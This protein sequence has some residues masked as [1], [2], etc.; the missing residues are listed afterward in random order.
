MRGS[1]ILGLAAGI[2]LLGQALPVEAGLL[3]STVDVSVLFPDQAT[4]FLDAGNK[5]VGDQIE[6]PVG[7]FSS[8]N[9]NL[10]VDITDTQIIVSLNGTDTLFSSATFNGLAITDLSGS[11]ASALGDGSSGFNPNNITIVGN[12]LFLNFQGIPTS[13]AGDISTID[14]ETAAT[15][16]PEPGTTPTTDVP[17][18]VTV[19]LFGAGLVGLGLMRRR[20]AA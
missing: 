20:R 18:P 17:E 15:T 1:I 13:Q 12:T 6:Y 16:E 5:V 11:F 3:G 10:S 19:A 4:L 14:I 8:Y 7:S 2:A 9:A